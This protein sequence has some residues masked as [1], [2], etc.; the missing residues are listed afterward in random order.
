MSFCKT[1]DP[2]D[3]VI[4]IVKKITFLAVLNILISAYKFDSLER[5]IKGAAPQ[6]I[7][8]RRLDLSEISS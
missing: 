5:E 6:N 7:K 3:Y 2:L 1:D 8:A 4:Y